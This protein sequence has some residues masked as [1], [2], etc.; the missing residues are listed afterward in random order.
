MIQISVIVCTYNRADML[1]NA[2]ESLLQQT[3]AKDLFEIIVVDNASTDTTPAVVKSF[4]ANHPE[5]NIGLMREDCLG[6]GYARNAGFRRAQGE[7]VAFM[8]DDAQASQD[9]LE[10]ALSCFQEIQPPPFAIGGKILPIYNSPK[11]KWFKDEWETRTW[12]EQP[13]LLRKGESFSGSNMIF[14]K[15]VLQAYGG[16]DTRVGV[17]GVYLSVGEETGLFQR[18]WQ[19][20]GA[21]CFYY[22]PRLVVYHAV[23]HYKMTVSY[24]LKRA[25][26]TGQVCLVQNPPDSMV[27]RLELLVRIVVSVAVYTLLALIPRREYW[28]LPYWAVTCL[29]PIAAEIGRF[30]GCIGLFIQVRQENR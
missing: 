10:T 27:K 24:S 3:L 26:V 25:F 5:H 6:L 23:P 18:I 16:F 30:V 14:K 2:L 29:T 20:E 28:A 15:E 9:W 13:R 7:Y 12:G 22:S 8:D 17:K 19:E 1:A 11:P 21:A 4:Q